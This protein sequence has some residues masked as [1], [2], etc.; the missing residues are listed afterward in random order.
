MLETPPAPQSQ[1]SMFSAEDFPAK[2]SRWLDVVQDWLENAPGCGSSFAE[3]LRNFDLRMSSS[4][5][6]PACYPAIEG[7]TLPP[8]FKGWSNSGMAWPGGSLTL[9][10]SECPSDAVES[11]L[12]AVLEPTPAS[13]YYLSQRACAG[14]LR[15]AAK[16]GKALPPRLEAALQV[17]AHTESHQEQTGAHSS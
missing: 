17:V 16:R 5:T 14:I 6:S 13:K 10:T 3:L 8:S 1:P 15:R 11:S 9:V 7:P 4:R 12:S 2:T